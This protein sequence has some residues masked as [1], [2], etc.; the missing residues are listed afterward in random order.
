M[1]MGLAVVGSVEVRS[2]ESSD[3]KR[4][5]TV[6]ALLAVHIPSRAARVSKRPFITFGGQKAHAELR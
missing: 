1:A 3:L 6:A 5:L 2:V 4:S